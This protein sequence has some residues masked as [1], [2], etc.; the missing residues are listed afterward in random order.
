MKLRNGLQRINDTS[1]KINDMTTELEKVAELI[2]AR[3]K[4]CEEMFAV[5]SKYLME[6]DEQKSKIDSICT[7]IKADE[8][9]CQEMYDLALSELKHTVPELEEATNV[10]R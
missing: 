8:L 3:T 9:K 5:I 6:I 4:Q 1:R 7:K 10:R 2:T